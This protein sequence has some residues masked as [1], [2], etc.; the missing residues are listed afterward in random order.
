MIL[1]CNC[2]HEYQDRRY[3]SKKRVHNE[4]QAAGA[5]NSLRFRC[6]VCGALRGLSDGQQH[7]NKDQK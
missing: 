7:V 3:G 5:V 6:T 2:N 1:K 4:R